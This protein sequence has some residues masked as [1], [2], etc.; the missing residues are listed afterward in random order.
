[1]LAFRSLCLDPFR[2]PNRQNEPPVYQSMK[3]A[4]DENAVS[5]TFFFFLVVQRRATQLEHGGRVD[6]L[7][8]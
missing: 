1:M 6:F 7:N 5:Y 8:W 2:S 3:R 4:K